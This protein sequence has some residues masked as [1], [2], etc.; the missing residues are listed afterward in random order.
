[1]EKT[2]A[3]IILSIVSPLYNEEGNVQPLI[4]RINAA[5]FPLGVSYEIILVDDGSQDSTWDAISTVCVENEIVVGIQ[6]S[7][8][9]GHQHAL[10][11][12]LSAARGRAIVSLDGDLQHPPESIPKMFDLWRKGYE[13]VHTKRYDKE[14]ASLFKRLSSKLFYR[15][16]SAM[17][18]VI[19][20]RGSSDFRLLDRKVLDT[21][22]TFKDI[23][24]F[25]RGAVQWVGFKATTLPF[26]AEARFS[27]TTKYSL[28]KMLKFALSAIIS[29]STI[30]LKISIYIGFLTTLL[31]SIEIIYILIVYLLDYTVPGWASIMGIISFLFGIMFINLGII[32]I[33]LARIHESSQH[34]PRFIVSEVLVSPQKGDGCDGFNS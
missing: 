28:R 6:L 15:F 33:Y 10:L 9:F 31:A 14:V 21:I 32:G 30:P 22:L 24:L 13:I 20:H 2:K 3:K 19:L 12:G 18:N 29:F 7:R 5:V 1:M 27:G 8:N 4:E 26:D 17:T 23:D 34:R 11:A 16:F 25:F